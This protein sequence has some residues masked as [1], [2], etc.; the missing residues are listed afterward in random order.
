M[1]PE[2]V[3]FIRESHLKT[4]RA[5]KSKEEKGDFVKKAFAE[6]KE[7][8]STQRTLSGV[9]NVVEGGVKGKY[10]SALL[11]F[12]ILK[13]SFKFKG[14]FEAKCTCHLNG[15]K[16][17]SVWVLPLFWFGAPPLHWN[18]LFWLT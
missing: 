8:M 16:A 3:K 7:W 14:K 2:T 12:W 5:E 10:K 13:F 1:S 17:I 15:K 4:S 11:G 9:V 18:A 6:K